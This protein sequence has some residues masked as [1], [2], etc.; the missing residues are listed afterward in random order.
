MK[1]RRPLG[2]TLIETLAVLTIVFVLGG[3]VYASL[4]PAREAARRTKCVSNL[5]QLGQALRMYGE[6]YESL[7]LPPGEPADYWDLGLPGP[8]HIGSFVANYVRNCSVLFCPDYH[9]S[10]PES[11]LLTSYSWGI[12]GDP[13]MPG[14]SRFAALVAARGGQA[15]IIVCDQHN[16]VW[17]RTAEPRWTLKRVLLLRLDGE[18]SSRMVH[19]RDPIAT[20]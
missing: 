6:D 8:P 10:E 18:V 13:S 14:E 12:E 5:R 19:V 17:D 20:W 4:G 16:A 15:P 1:V 3:I 11:Q 2:F 9:G 7:D